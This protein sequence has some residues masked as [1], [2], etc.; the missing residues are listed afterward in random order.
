MSSSR[1]RGYVSKSFQAQRHRSSGWEKYVPFQAKKCS[2]VTMDVCNIATTTLVGGFGNPHKLKS[3]V[4]LSMT[5][6][7]SNTQTLFPSFPFV[8]NAKRGKA[9]LR[10]II[11][12]MMRKHLSQHCFDHL[13]VGLCFWDGLVNCWPLRIWLRWAVHASLPVLPHLL[14]F[15][16]GSRRPFRLSHH[17]PGFSSRPARPFHHRGRSPVL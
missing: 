2:G 3:G 10:E 17:R 14:A 1:V 16:P 15:L 8:F 4:R 13:P 6:L 9:K 11:A 7:V 12:C 5:R